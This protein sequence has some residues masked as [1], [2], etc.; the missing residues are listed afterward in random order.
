MPLEA[1]NESAVDAAEAAAVEN[2]TAPVPE[3]SPAPEPAPAPEPKAAAELPPKEPDKPAEPPKTGNPALDKPPGFAPNAAIREAREEARLLREQLA[4]LQAGKPPEPQPAEID[5]ETDPIAA[6]KEV[7]EFQQ[8]QREEAIQQHQL[9]EFDNRIQTH[10]AD[11]S[12]ANPDYGD[13]ITFLREFRAGQLKALFPGI[14]NA[15]LGQQLMKEVRETAFY[16][17]QNG[18]NPGEVFSDLATHSG[19]KAKDP[20]PEPAPAPAPEPPVDLEAKRAESN[21][22]LDRISRGQRAS[23]ATAGAGGNAPEAEM[24]LESIANLT[25]A[26]FDAAMDKHG[27]RLF[28]G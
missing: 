1:M 5:P 8:R 9:R 10:E 26:A 2:G 22:A 7:R 28:G 14:T 12:A 18:K 23:R 20:V 25:G 15:Q 27:K 3:P 6:L 17:F 24:T 13:Q 4:A 19:W 11:W 16:A 21:A